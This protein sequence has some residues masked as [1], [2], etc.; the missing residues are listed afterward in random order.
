MVTK[1]TLRTEKGRHAIFMRRSLQLFNNLKADAAK[2]EKL[3]QIDFDCESIREHI[4]SRIG[5]VCRGCGKIV[6][7]RTFSADHM[8]PTQR[9]GSHGIDNITF[10]YCVSCNKMKGDLTD[11]EFIDL[12]RF[13]ELKLSKEAESDIRRRLKA[14]G[15]VRSMGRSM[16]A[17]GNP[18]RK[19]ESKE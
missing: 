18:S 7:E 4:K 17:K 14:G 9:G 3:R 1:P 16:W 12:L 19:R 15:A 6:T 2:Q 5:L 8:Y 11:N 13:M 10:K